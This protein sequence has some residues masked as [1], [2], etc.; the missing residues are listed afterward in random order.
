MRNRAYLVG[1]IA[2]GYISEECLTFCSRYLESVETVFNRSIRN[3]EEFTGAM[4]S[5]TLDQ[6]SMT[7]V[8]RYVLFNCDEIIPFRK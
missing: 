8:H 4:L 5:I 3:N 1:S 2:E 7:Q 6:K